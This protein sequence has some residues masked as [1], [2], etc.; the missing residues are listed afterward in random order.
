MLIVKNLVKVLKKNLSIGPF[1]VFEMLRFVIMFFRYNYH[2]FISTSAFKTRYF[3]AWNQLHLVWFPR[4]NLRCR[5]LGVMFM[6]EKFH[7]WW[8]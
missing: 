5:E 1:H 6:F 8:R 3:R 2:V 4:D 7:N